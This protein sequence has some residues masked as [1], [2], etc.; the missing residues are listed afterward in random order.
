MSWL[1]SVFPL[2]DKSPLVTLDHEPLPERTALMANRNGSVH[3]RRVQVVLRKHLVPGFPE[4]VFLFQRR[5]GGWVGLD[6]PKRLWQVPGGHVRE[7]LREVAIQTSTFPSAEIEAVI[8]HSERKE[9]IEGTSPAVADLGDERPV[10]S[11][12]EIT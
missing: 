9:P 10:R 12:Q 6:V 11:R 1:E 8:V 7:R 2:A 5:V 3:D 4:P